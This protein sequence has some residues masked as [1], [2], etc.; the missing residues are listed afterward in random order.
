MFF[1]FIVKLRILSSGCRKVHQ[2]LIFFIFWKC[3]TLLDAY[4]L[5]I[6]MILKFFVS[7][8]FAWGCPFFIEVQ[9]FNDLNQYWLVLIL[10]FVWVLVFFVYLITGFLKVLLLVNHRLMMFSKFNFMTVFNSLSKNH[11][12]KDLN[13]A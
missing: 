6:K 8:D 13:E 4:L 10:T 11:T 5:K 12:F 9:S 3:I 1:S 2:M 7:D